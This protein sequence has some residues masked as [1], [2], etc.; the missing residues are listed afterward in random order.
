VKLNLIRLVF[1]SG[2]FL[3]HSINADIGF[4]KEDVDIA[5]SA[6][7]AGDKYAL[8]AEADGSFSIKSLDGKGSLKIDKSKVTTVDLPDKEKATEFNKIR[9]CIKNYLPDKKKRK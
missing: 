9:D 2:I 3:V 8:K 7:L 1:F 4:T 5:S 6:C